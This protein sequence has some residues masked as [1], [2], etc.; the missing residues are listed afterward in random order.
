MLKNHAGVASLTEAER[1]E[2]DIIVSPSNV[3]QKSPTEAARDDVRAVMNQHRKALQE[4]LR[5]ITQN[6]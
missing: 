1:R 6:A 2:I 3:S 4:T 5:K